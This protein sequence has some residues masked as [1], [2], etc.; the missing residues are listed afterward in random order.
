MV[1]NTIARDLESL[2][3]KMAPFPQREAEATVA[4]AFDKPLAA[5]YSSFGPAVAAASIAQV[6]RAEV[7]SNGKRKAV[8]VK[9][10]GPVSNAVSN[11]IF[12]PCFLPPAKRKHSRPKRS[13]CVLLRWFRRWPVPSLSRWISAWKRRPRPRLAENT[14]DD[15]DFRVPRHR[16]GPHGTLGPHTQRD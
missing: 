4:T 1:G 7:D 10:C 9:F 12:P 8:A 14:R 5:V 2:Q 11:Q 13:V 16:R 6:H 15:T 3:D